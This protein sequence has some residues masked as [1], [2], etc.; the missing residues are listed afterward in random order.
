MCCILLGLSLILKL[1]EQDRAL[2]ASCY[3][4]CLEL[5][6]EYKLRSVAFCCISTGVFRFPNEDAAQIAV[7]TVLQ[8][9]QKDSTIEQV[10]FNVFQDKDL[11][12]YQ[13][14]LG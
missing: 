2:L 12:I 3:R 8:F 5:A 6:A 11:Q 7:D 4:S 10:I 13:R 1:L 14:L 9:L